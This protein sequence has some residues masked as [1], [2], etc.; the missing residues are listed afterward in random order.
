MNQTTARPDAWMPLYVADYLADTTRLTTIQHGA[1][2]LLIMAYW[3]DGEALPD[4]DNDLAAITRLP[5]KDWRRIRPKLEP[6]FDLEAGAWRHARIEYELKRATEKLEQ[7]K[8]AGKAS[9]QARADRRNVN[10]RFNGTSTPVATGVGAER[11]TE[12]QPNVNPSPS[13]SPIEDS[14]A[15]AT[16]A[17]APPAE[18]SERDLVWGDGLRWLANAEGKPIN[19]LRSMLGRWCAVYGDAHVLAVMTEARGQ[20]PPIV[21]PV[22]WIE[23]TLKTRNQGNGGQHR[24]AR[25]PSNGF[26]AA[27]LDGIDRRAG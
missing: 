9:A 19:P 10:A 13:P 1:Y 22:A 21:G 27:A 7:Q 20:S 16:G 6:F 24:R 5:V 26:V 8:M 17:D 25:P 2:L 23:A 18:L 3:R 12:G 4:D 11:A 15:K 14:V